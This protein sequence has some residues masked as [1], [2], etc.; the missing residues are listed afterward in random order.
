MGGWHAI[1]AGAQ[2]I[3]E[4]RAERTRQAWPE[5][6]P[7]KELAHSAIAGLFYIQEHRSTD[8]CKPGYIWA[9]GPVCHIVSKAVEFAQPIKCRGDKGLWDLSDELRRKIR[10]QLTAAA[11]SHFDLSPAIRV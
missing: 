1:H 11:V 5:A 8:Q 9:R 4:E 6:P 2:F 7:E 10:Q 3:N